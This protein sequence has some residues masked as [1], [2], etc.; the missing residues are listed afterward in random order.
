MRVV[1][2]GTP[3]LA[4][5]ILDALA[6]AHDVVGVF[7]R[8]DAVRGR[9]RQLVGSPVKVA[10]V[11][12]GIPVVTLKSLRE[13]DAI[14]RLRAFDPDVICVAACGII[15]PPE[16]LGVPRHG[17]LNVHT[18]LLPRW[19]GAAPMQRSIL[20]CDDETGVCIMRMEEGLDTGAYCKR[21][22]VPLAGVYLADLES[23]LAK[24]GSRLLLEALDELQSGTIE[25]TEQ[26]ERGVTYAP[27]LESR[28]L[29]LDP[30]DTACALCAKVR[31]S[32]DA[33]AAHA[34]LAGRSVTV[35]RAS[36][37]GDERAAGICAGLAA[38]QALFREKRLFAMAADGPVEI[39]QLKPQG[40]KS[41]DARSFA[42]GIQGAK[43][44]MLTWGRA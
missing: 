24:A 6:D 27:K 5:S 25:W 14:Q 28:E 38:G 34:M 31:A 43:N 29:D 7:T 13:G 26:P 15:F 16:A 21:A 33:H 37:P 35:Q 41:M 30:A 3:E 8:P 17:C 12:R 32:D 18:S 4:A 19:R 39:E 23:A 11:K 1:F 10:A 42:A 2:M 22:S 40:K 36:V 20:A 44:S 9:G